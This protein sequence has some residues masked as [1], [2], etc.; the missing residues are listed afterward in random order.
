LI[1]HGV[2]HSRTGTRWLRVANEIGNANGLR[3]KVVHSVWGY[4]PRDPELL[5]A[6]DRRPKGRK[7]H[8][9]LDVDTINDLGRKIGALSFELMFPRGLSDALQPRA[10]ASRSLRLSHRTKQLASRDL[11]E[12]SPQEGTPPQPSSAGSPLEIPAIV[13]GVSFEKLK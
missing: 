9:P 1:S 8:A 12:D 3:Q 7:H 5:W 6:S 10:F 13:F 2:K 11:Q 4:N